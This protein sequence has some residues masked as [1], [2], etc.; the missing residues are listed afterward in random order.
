MKHGFCKPIQC[1]SQRISRRINH[2]PYKQRGMGLTGWLFVITIFGFSLT[3]GMKILPL[4][5]DHSTMLG[6][7]DGMTEQRGLAA[8]STPELDKILDQRFRVNNI[9]EFNYEDNVT[10]EREGE[11]VFI[12]LAYEVRVPLIRN[13]DLIVYFDDSVEL[14]D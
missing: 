1:E 6:V 14:K 3:V 2:R 11:T 7:M 10:M 5:I 9:L 4:Y 8:L 13:I 12:I